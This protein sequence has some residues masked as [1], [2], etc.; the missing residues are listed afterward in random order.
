MISLIKLG[1][2]SCFILLGSALLYVNTGITFIE[3]IYALY[4]T[5]EVMLIQSQDWILSL[6]ENQVKEKWIKTNEVN[7]IESF[8]I[9]LII[10]SIGYLFKVSSAP[11]HFWSPDVY[12]SLPTLV[13]TFVAIMAKISIFIF[14]LDLVHFSSE[15][16]TEFFWT[17]ILQ[18]DVRNL[19]F[20]DLLSNSWYTLKLFISNYNWEIINGWINYSCMVI[21]N[22]IFEKDMGNQGSK[23]ITSS[24]NVIIKEQ[25]VYDSWQLNNIPCLRSTLT[26]FERNYQIKIFSYQIN[27]WRSYT[28]VAAN[29]HKLDNTSLLN[30]YFLTGFVDGEGCFSILIGKSPQYKTGWKV[31][32]V[33]EISLHK[34]DLA[35][36]EFIKF[37]FGG[38][39]NIT[40]HGKDKIH[41]RVTSKADL[42]T[43]IDHFNKYPLLTQ[44]KADFLLFKKA[45]DLID[46]K[47]HL[48]IEGLQK[49][50]AIRAVINRGLSND[51][52]AAFPNIV[53]ITRPLVVN[54]KIEDPNWVSGFTSGEG[55]FLI[56]IYKSSTKLGESVKL[57]FILTQHDK[58]KQFMQS[59]ID[60]FGAG[61]VYK[62]HEAIDFKITKI[63]YITDKLIPFFD[64][65]KIIG[66]KTKNY[67]YFKKVA[68]LIKN[69]AHLTS[70]VI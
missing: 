24:K 66:E 26:G 52:K 50:V 36:L 61:N 60:Y 51:L 48:T 22:K 49:I 65:Y 58:D 39:G 11:F 12:D 16:K 64:K 14:M 1:L 40:K 54:Q 6:F 18:V 33:F 2:S 17:D 35:I 43:I 10:L 37:Y 4:S 8:D 29:S 44:K 28:S 21:S 57:V 38:L 7:P 42:S 56:N 34:K 3:G 63:D 31:Q 46:Q 59:L 70:E 23:L 9:S 5:T 53:P 68:Q 47:E 55:C 27:K 19:L 15:A 25:R 30:P 45:V 41:L 32:A 67:S 69:G 62:N 20:W 13:T